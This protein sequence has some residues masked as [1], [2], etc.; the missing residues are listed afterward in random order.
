MTADDLEA[1]SANLKQWAQVGDDPER[2]TE[3]QQEAKVDVVIGT[4]LAKH[5]GRELTLI[6]EVLRLRKQRAELED[7]LAT[8]VRQFE[9][10]MDDWYAEKERVAEL[11]QEAGVEKEHWVEC[12]QRVTEERNAALA[13]VARLSGCHYAGPAVHPAVIQRL[14]LDK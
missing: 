13:T 2:L 4:P 8:T 9:S 7:L 10:C 6:D 11:E 1:M 3:W 14:R 5:I 12:I